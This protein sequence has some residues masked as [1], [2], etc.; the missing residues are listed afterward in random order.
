MPTRS[1]GDE[2]SR[3]RELQRFADA[4]IHDLRAPLRG[5]NM[6]ASLLAREWNERFDDGAKAHLTSIFAGA[7]KL[8]ELAKSLSDYSM[9]LLPDRSVFLT[10]PLDN[11]LN[12]ALISL[13]DEIQTSQ[14]SVHFESLPQ[15]EANH[16]QMSV[17]FRCLLSNSIEYRGSDSPR[18][19][20]SASRNGEEWRFNFTDNGI[21][22]AAR[23]RDKVFEPFQRLHSGPR[24]VGLGLT[25]CKRI[26]EGHGG[27]IRLESE[28]G[29]GTTVTFTLQAA[30]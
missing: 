12:T 29:R 6:S 28:E 20:I 19:E 1:S 9:A 18:I 25:I 3:V 10:L 15:V 21:G 16:E 4:A 8:E 26:V 27:Q 11:A 24:G 14:S 5:I 30:S 23:Y 2:P 13:R 7:A 22:I 17:L